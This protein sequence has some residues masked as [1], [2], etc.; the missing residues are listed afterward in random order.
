MIDIGRISLAFALAGTLSACAHA[1]DPIA[2]GDRYVN[3]GSSFASGAGAGPLAPGAPQ[4]CYQS[5]SNY[6][7][8]LAARLSLDLVDVSC[9]GATSAHMITAWNELPAQVDAVTTDTRLVTITVGGNDIAL[10]GNLTA[11]SCEQ[12][13]FIHAAGMTLPCPAAFPVAEEAYVSLERNLRE[14]SRRLSERAPRAQVIFIQYLKLVPWTQCSQTR[15]TEPEAAALRASAQR[16]AEITERVAR[17]SGYD[18]LRMDQFARRHTPCDADPWS[19][20]LPSD[21]DEAMGAPWHPNARGMDAT[22]TRLE[23]LLRQRERHSP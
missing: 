13:E 5:L 8:L 2:A 20:G 9:A 22:A 10:A 21:Y 4:R 15:L 18:V 16:L 7:R 23:L 11:A 17:E 12:G 6:A 14:L 19:T 1:H 3:M